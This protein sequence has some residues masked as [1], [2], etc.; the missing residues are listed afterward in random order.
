MADPFIYVIVAIDY[1]VENFLPMLYM[2]KL[3]LREG[4]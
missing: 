4:K 1:E 2:R 3:G